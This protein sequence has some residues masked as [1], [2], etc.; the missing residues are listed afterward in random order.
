VTERWT[1]EACGIFFGRFRDFAQ[2][3]AALH[4]NPSP[5]VVEAIERI[6]ARLR[7]AD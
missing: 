3:N 5:E 7:R 4:W 2:H 6:V 1:C